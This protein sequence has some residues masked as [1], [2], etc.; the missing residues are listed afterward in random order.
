[1]SED[2][3]AKKAGLQKGDIVVKLGDST[4]VDMMSYMRALSVF[5]EGDTTKAVIKR[6]GEEMEFDIEFK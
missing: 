2:K 5:G 6:N 3:P 4:I 1:V